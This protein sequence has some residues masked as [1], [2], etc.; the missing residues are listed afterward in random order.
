MLSKWAENTKCPSIILSDLYLETKNLNNILNF[1]YSFKKTKY[2]I[3]YDCIR[4]TTFVKHI[5]KITKKGNILKI[6]KL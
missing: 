6:S 1:Y 3:Q 2:L 4:P 5:K